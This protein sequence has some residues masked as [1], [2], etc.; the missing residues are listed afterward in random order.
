LDEPFGA[1]DP[2]TRSEIQQE[3]R[4]V[5]RKLNKTAIFVTHDMR[6]AFLLA[7]RIGLMQNGKLIAIVQPEEFLNLD[8]PEAQAFARCLQ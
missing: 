6:E 5:H 4:E 7:T 3:F 8:H 2:I 1:L